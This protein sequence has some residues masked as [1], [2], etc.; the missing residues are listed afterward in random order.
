MGAQSPTHHVIGA[1]A[2]RQFGVVSR[3]PQ[4]AAGVGR[5]AIRRGL[6]AHRLRPLLRGVYALGHTALR[7]ES[8][9][10]AALPA[11]REGSALS[12]QTA[13]SLWGFLTADALP[14]HL[15]TGSDRGRTQR[16]IVTHRIRLH[17]YDPLLRDGPRV[18]APA[19]TIIDLAAHHSGRALRD[20]P[21]RAQDPGR[22]SADDI[23][24]TL[25]RFPRGPGTRRL[26]D[27]IALAQA[28][29]DKARSD[30]ERFFLNVR[31]MHAC[32]ARRSTK[33]SPA[34]KGTS[35]IARGWRPLRFTF[36]EIAFEPGDVARELTRLLR[37]APA[38]APRT[39]APSA[40]LRGGSRRGP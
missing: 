29:K 36:E 12:H 1:L 27:L 38:A 35:L 21:E 25:A 13:A 3:E 22:V 4:L 26:A 31:E 28:D 30:L 39:R 5:G 18:T 16:R 40:P 9:W 33:R 37:P 19:R 23:G 34:A 20:I 8:W 15:T 7:R 32:P 17:G 6:Q 2:G 10:Q 24:A 11:S 14:V